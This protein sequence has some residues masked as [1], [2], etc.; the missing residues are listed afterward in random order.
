M[1]RLQSMPYEHVKSLLPGRAQ[2][3]YD[4]EQTYPW[5][6]MRQP[7]NFTSTIATCKQCGHGP[8]HHIILEH[9]S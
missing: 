5:T 8:V 9:A 3:K 4:S 2:A 6:G 1:A 7:E